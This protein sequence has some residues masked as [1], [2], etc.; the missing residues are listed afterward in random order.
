[1]GYVWCVGTLLQARGKG[2]SR[3]LIDESM[4][5]M[6]KTGLSNLLA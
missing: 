3:M 1:M 5:Q 2:Y 4:E 6:G